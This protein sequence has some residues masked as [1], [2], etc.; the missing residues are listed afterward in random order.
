MT[1]LILLSIVSF[2]FAAPAQAAGGSVYNIERIPRD[3][4]GAAW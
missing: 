1:Q 3:T 4:C 2:F